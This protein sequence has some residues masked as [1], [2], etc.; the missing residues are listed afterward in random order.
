MA[1]SSQA[2]LQI[3]NIS[4]NFG[5]IQALA[6]VSF[7]IR[8]NEILG[9]IGPNGSGKT[10]LLEGICGLIPVD[11]GKVMHEEKTIP[12]ARRRKRMFY[13]PDG[14]VPY[15]EMSV[16]H[17]LDFFRG[18]FQRDKKLLNRVIKQLELDSV[19]H[20]KVKTLSKGYNRRC[21]LAVALLSPQK[22]LILD[23]PFDGLDLKQM[24][25]VME[26]LKET[27]ASGRS[28]LLSIHQLSDAQRICNRYILLDEGKLLGMGTLEDLRSQAGISRGGLEEVFL[29]LT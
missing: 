9:L 24:L 18:L 26:I 20:K 2:I 13:L 3:A 6:G 27:C 14:I 11:D 19:L 4:K 22:L 1:S 16:L 29:A 8:P 21:L 5:E 7:S 25:G 28:L 10:T 15:P 12:I 17:V 23:E